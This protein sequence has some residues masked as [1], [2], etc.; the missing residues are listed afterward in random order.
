[1]TGGETR[2]F[3]RGDMYF[4]R[5][6]RWSVDYMRKSGFKFLPADSKDVLM[7]GYLAHATGMGKERQ[8]HVEA[9]TAA[10]RVGAFLKA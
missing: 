10:G 5:L 4:T 8:S 7:A 1:M 9:G 3:D 6:K 2:E